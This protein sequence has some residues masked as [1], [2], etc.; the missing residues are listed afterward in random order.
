MAVEWLTWEAERTGLSLSGTRST[1]EG[2]GSVNTR[3]TDGEAKRGRRTSSKDAT[4]KA[5]R[6]SV[7][8]RTP[9]TGSP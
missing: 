7:W 9:S 4:T 2:R 8:K 5:A 1:V 6:A 3:W